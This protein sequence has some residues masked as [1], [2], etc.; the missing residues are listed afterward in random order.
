[1]LEMTIR[2]LFVLTSY[3]F[4]AFKL[5]TSATALLPPDVDEYSTQN[6][7][8]TF[9]VLLVVSFSLQTLSV[10]KKIYEQTHTDVFFM[11]WEKPRAKL[12]DADSVNTVDAPVS[13]WRTILVAN[14][15]NEMQTVRKTNVELTIVC[16]VFLLVG[17]RLEYLATP[18]P[19]ASDLSTGPLNLYLRFANTAFWWLL[20]SYAQVFWRWVV[21]ERDAPTASTLPEDDQPPTVAERRLDPVR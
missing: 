21:Y 6:E 14:E 3:Y 1:M 19:T 10:F 13:V 2:L 12:V 7:Y 4:I 9:Q 18:Q 5:G 8:Y 20:L 16:M 15:W 11:D 17:C